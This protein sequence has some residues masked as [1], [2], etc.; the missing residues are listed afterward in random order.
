MNCKYC[1]KHL[2]GEVVRGCHRA[3]YRYQHR[4]AADGRLDL[5]EQVRLGL[6]GPKGKPG[7]KAKVKARKVAK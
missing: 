3:C 7:P 2:S 6:L 5:A 1:G 4:L